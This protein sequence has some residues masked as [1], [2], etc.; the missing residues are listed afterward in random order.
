MR[1]S[2]K[3]RGKYTGVNIIRNF[4]TNS[5]VPLKGVHYKYKPSVAC[6]VGYAHVLNDMPL[7]HK[8]RCLKRWYGYVHDLNN[9][10]ME[11]IQGIYIT[12]QEYVNALN[13]IPLEWN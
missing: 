5:V 13:G 11:L 9:M 2:L 12:I 1:K 3:K 6:I 7:E 8:F 10:S 4:I